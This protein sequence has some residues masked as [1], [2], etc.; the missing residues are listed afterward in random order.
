MS[1]GHWSPR[2]MC[3]NG[4]H[5]RRCSP[6]QFVITGAI[7]AAETA[8]THFAAFPL[9]LQCLSFAE[10]YISHLTLHS[11][12]LIAIICRLP[13]PGQ[14]RASF[15]PDLTVHTAFVL[16]CSTFPAA[17][18]VFRAVDVVIIVAHYSVRLFVLHHFDCVAYFCVRR[19]RRRAHKT[20]IFCL[21]AFELHCAG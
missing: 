16:L 9:I 5:S 11:L 7:H 3:Q 8:F 14:D 15:G 4:L 6:M 17:Q 1:H 19:R 21:N 12:K 20:T 13:E 10:A 2:E 18:V